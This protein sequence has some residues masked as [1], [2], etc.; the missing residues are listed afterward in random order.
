MRYFIRICLLGFITSCTGIID[1]PLD[2]RGEGSD[3]GPSAVAEQNA[4]QD[5]PTANNDSSVHF[6]APCAMCHEEDRKSP[7][8]FTGQDCA[9]CHSYPS[10]AETT[11]AFSHTPKPETCEQCHQRPASG[12]RA[13]PNQG[14]PD[15]FDPDANSP[16]SGHYVG[17]D[18]VS[19]HQTPDEGQ[20]QF[21][22]THS[23]PQPG[24]CLP[25]H[26]NDGQGEHLNDGDVMLSDL[27]N[28][29]SCHQ[30]FDANQ[31]RNFE[32]VNGDD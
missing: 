20:P 21:V 3:A 17:Q 4:N 9:S 16:G 12:L 23:S 7:D 26:F 13:Y 22:F 28:C 8:H 11:V 15:G 19:C 6:E 5:T 27:G 31:T 10:W 2:K 24:V 30:N 25:C 18:C 29:A 14:P 1:S 32:P